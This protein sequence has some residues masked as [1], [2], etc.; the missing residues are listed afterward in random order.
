MMTKLKTVGLAVLGGAVG[1]V[2]V[3][4]AIHAY[5]D[6]QDFHKIREAIIKAAQARPALPMTD[7]GK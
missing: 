5:V 6:H 3:L 4:M 7:A 2:L 1:I